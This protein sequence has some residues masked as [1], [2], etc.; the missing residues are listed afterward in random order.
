MKIGVLG[1][2][3]DPIQNAHVGMAR[4]AAEELSLDLVLLLPAGNPYFKKG[5]TPY[6]LRLA[7]TEAAA[8]CLIQEG[9]RTEVSLLEAD[10]SRPTYTCDTLAELRRQYPEDEIFFICGADVLK[11]IHTFRKPEEILRLAKLAV[12]DRGKDPEFDTALEAFHER[13][14]EGECVPLRGELPDIS[15]TLVRERIKCGE[16]ISELVPPEV[17]EYI[18]SQGLYRSFAEGTASCTTERKCLSSSPEKV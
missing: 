1:G 4:L 9:I 8:K 12:F 18:E 3:F 10:E 7:M 15:S 5:V 16:D 11:T 17:A 13:F 14:P 2:S 6:A